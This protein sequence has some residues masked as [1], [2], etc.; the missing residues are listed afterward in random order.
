[1]MEW[2]Q[3]G[4]AENGVDVPASVQYMKGHMAVLPAFFNRLGEER[5][6]GRPGPDK[7]SAKEILGHL[8]DS[9]V[10]N[11]VRFTSIPFAPSPYQI[12]P[13]AQV[14]LVR[15]NRYQEL[16]LPHLLVLW[17]SLNR[18]ILYVIEGLTAEQLALPV[19]PG[20]ADQATRTLGWVFCDYVAHL[21]HHLSQIYERARS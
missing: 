19:R 9:A 6:V 21:E 1:M 4:F 5:L 20:Y 10:H 14:E 16:P 13:Y 2:Q 3:H 17:E 8:A 11:L 15:V 18:Q 12:H 7:W